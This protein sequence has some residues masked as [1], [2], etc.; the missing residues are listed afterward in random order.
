MSKNISNNRSKTKTRTLP[1]FYQFFIAFLLIAFIAFSLWSAKQASSNGTNVTD[2]D[3]YSKGL[4]YNKTLV[5]QRAALVLGWQVDTALVGRNLQI[6][7][8]DSKKQPVV[9]AKGEVFLYY[10]ASGTT[11]NLSLIERTSGLYSLN[12][13]AEISG[14][15]RAR[16]VIELDGAKVSRQI[17]LNL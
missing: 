13:P 4:R 16:L 6:S 17:L 15:V 14:E 9:G 2:S 5:E 12:L 7:L 1:N 11:T 8:A 10:D 3:Y